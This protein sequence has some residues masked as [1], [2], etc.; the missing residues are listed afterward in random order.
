[1]RHLRHTVVAVLAVA[2]LLAPA[3]TARERQHHHGGPAVSPAGGKLLGEAW[4]RGLSTPDPDP[5]RGACAPVARGGTIVAP[6]FG[7]DGTAGC[8]ITRGSSI[9]VFWSFF[10]SDVFEGVSGEQAQRKCAIAGD[11]SVQSID[12]SID[13]RPPIALRRPRYE[14]LSPQRTVQL[15]DGSGPITF[16]AHGWAALIRDLRP[17]QHTIGVQVINEDFQ[18]TGT[19]LVTVFGRAHS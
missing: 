4:A 17:G 8:E 16:V 11:Q 1:M 5:Y 12:V 2:L 13:H 18:F 3:A 10:C 15:G 14:A 19:L 6:H 7:D 9:L